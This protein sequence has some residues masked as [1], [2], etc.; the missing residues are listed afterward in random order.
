MNQTEKFL[1]D[2]HGFIHIP[3]FL[4]KRSSARML[5]ACQRIEHVPACE[6]S[7]P[8]FVAPTSGFEF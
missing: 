1:F 2:C 4:S 7:A 5:E 6:E 8:R 3:E